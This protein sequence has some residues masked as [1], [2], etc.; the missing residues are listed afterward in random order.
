MKRKATFLVL[1]TFLVQY[2]YAQQAKTLLGR[3]NDEKGLPLIGASVYVTNEKYNAV[4]DKNGDFRVAY[5]NESNYLKI[6]FIGYKTVDISIS[7]F[8][9][10]GKVNLSPDGNDMDEV[11][12]VGYGAQKKATVTG[13]VAQVTGAEMLKSP[14]GN[15]SGALVGRVS[16]I[17]TFQKSGQP[18]NDAT[19]IRIRGT[20]TFAGSSSPLVIVDGVQRSFEQLDMEEIETISVLKDASATAVYGVRGANGVIVVT[21]KRG[22]QGPAKVSYTSNLSLQTPTRMPKPL[23][24]Y[25]FARLFNEGMLNDNPL[26]APRYTAEDL[27][28]YQDGSDPIFYP[29]TN[30]YDMVMAK[31]ELQQ[32]HNVNINGG[33]KFARYFV[34][35]G[36]FTQGGLQKEFNESYGYSNK[37]DYKRF[38]YRS[39]IDMDVTPTTKIALTLGGKKGDKRRVPG[40][41]FYRDIINTPALTTPGI[42]NGKLIFL[43]NQALRNPVANLMTGLDTYSENHLEINLQG[44]QKLDALI[45]GLSLK[46]TFAYDNDYRQ[47]I[48]RSKA[49]PTYTAIR[50]IVDG[51]SR[52]VYRQAGEATELGAPTETYDQLNERIYME[53]ALT[54]QQKFGKHEVSGLALANSSK[55]WFPGGG[56]PGVP[57]SYMEFVGRATYNYDYKYLAEVNMGYNGS[58]NFPSKSRFGFFPAASVGWVA[59]EEALF[60]KIISAKVLSYLKFRASYG[61][62]GNDALN[63]ER[64]LYFPSEYVSGDS[65]VFGETPISYTGYKEGKIGNANVTWEKAVKQNYGVETKF[66]SN[67][68]SIN[69]DYFYDKRDNILTNLQTVP[70]HTGIQNYGA[71]NIGATQNRG[72]ELEL[73]WDHQV[74]K[75]NYWIKSNYSFAR[76]KIIEMDEAMDRD[77]PQLWRTGKRIGEVFGYTFAGFFNDQ[78]EVNA[79]PSQFGFTL[80]PGDVKFK[81][82]N[83]DGV[84]DTR[85]LSPMLNPT[86][87]E[88]SYAFSGGFSVANFDMSFLFQGS[89]NVSSSLGQEFMKPFSALGSGFEHALDR[90]Y[91]GNE[92]NAKYPKLTVNYTND[93]NYMSSRIYTQDAAYLRLRNV[94]A[95]YKFDFKSLGISSIRVFVSGQNLLTWDKLGIIDPEASASTNMTYPQL[96]IYNVGLNVKF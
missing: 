79:W 50:A 71:Y 92:A 64:F 29:N 43:E 34:S 14:V 27:Q 69:L 39:N 72:F 21:T 86:F 46:G 57:I 70:S 44:T 3:V 76:N 62:V 91:P 55:R 18:G 54:Y 78:D 23:N 41:V 48:S 36:Y 26:A 33:T 16:G 47:K 2:V 22:L 65:Y 6:T 30:W 80:G 77:N 52:V 53:A 31:N 90:W 28:K 89:A 94:E 87:P 37:D 8:K 84:I 35:L 75:V 45:K 1:F 63:S 51:E 12:I 32:K 15:A 95:G 73:G 42:I 24:S 96:K 38:N 4:T 85:D 9:R 88:I 13:A 10:S 20:G 49:E 74:G 60:K 7:E 11:I 83:G 25:D 82:I 17:Q 61:E 67:K 93:N 40:S 19:E 58:E 68:L 59:S 5:D 81:D 66:L 56:F